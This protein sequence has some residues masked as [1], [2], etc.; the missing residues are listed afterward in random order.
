MTGRGLAAKSHL[1]YTVDHVWPPLHKAYPSP[2]SRSYPNTTPSPSIPTATTDLTMPSDNEYDDEY[3]D[4]DEDMYDGTQEDEESKHPLLTAP[5]PVSS[6]RPSLRRRH[7]PR[8][9]L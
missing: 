8:R 2:P 1:L 5:S 4:S 7:G 3:Y 9:R 6:P